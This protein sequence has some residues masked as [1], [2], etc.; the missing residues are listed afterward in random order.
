MAQAD[1]CFS[2]RF[3]SL[4]VPTGFPTQKS[5]TSRRHLRSSDR[6]FEGKGYERINWIHYRGVIPSLHHSITPVVGKIGVPK[7]ISFAQTQDELTPVVPPKAGCPWPPRTP[8]FKNKRFLKIIGVP[9]GI[10][11]P[12]ADVKGRCPWPLDDGDFPN[13]DCA[14]RS[15][16]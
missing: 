7:G 2:I 8:S 14:I 10:R 4:V 11:T 9:K 12:V 6:G 15:A 5:R 13:L 3:L 16:E 1:S